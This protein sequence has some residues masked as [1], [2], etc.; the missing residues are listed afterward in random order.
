M[1]LT[2]SNNHVAKIVAQIREQW[3]LEICGYLAG[4][5]G[6]VLDVHAV[7][8]ISASPHN[9][10]VMEPQSQLNAL[11]SVQAIKQEILAVYHSHPVRARYDLSEADLAGQVDGNLLQ[12]VVVPN[13]QREI[14]SMRVF[15]IKVGRQIE[16][17]LNIEP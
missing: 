5:G 13:N 6:K 4:A 9:S 2:I 7:K 10:F 1:N 8:N 16:V 3:P 11:V 15:R 12:V 14:E 17:P